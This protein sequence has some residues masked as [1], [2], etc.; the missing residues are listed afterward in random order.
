MITNFNIKI[1]KLTEEN[2][3]IGKEINDLH[4]KQ[5]FNE[6]KIRGYKNM[7]YFEHLFLSHGVSNILKEK[8]KYIDNE[9]I[10]TQYNDNEMCN[11]DTILIVFYGYKLCIKIHLPDDYKPLKE[12]ENDIYLEI[13]QMKGYLNSRKIYLSKENIN[14]I[15]TNILNEIKID[16]NNK[17]MESMLNLCSL[18]LKELSVLYKYNID[19]VDNSKLQKIR[20]HA[21][22]NSW[23]HQII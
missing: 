18:V 23:H 6:K 4:K 19:I 20:I 17:N 11:I 12:C 9:L 2:Q 3:F 1:K 21:I 5:Y 15:F 8:I 10:R 16:S 14:E 22:K 7:I 13:D